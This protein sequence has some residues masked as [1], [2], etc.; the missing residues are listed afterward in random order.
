M[1]FNGSLRFESWVEIQGN[2]GV[3]LMVL[4]VAGEDLERNVNRD[5]K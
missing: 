3:D 1:I 5:Q 2:G 4:R